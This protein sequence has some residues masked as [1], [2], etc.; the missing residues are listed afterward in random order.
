MVKKKMNRLLRPNMSVFFFAMGA[1]SIAAFILEQYWLG[2]IQG[3]A[4]LLLYAINNMDRRHRHRELS[5]YLLEVENTLE[6]SGQGRSPF[7]AVMVRLGDGG[8]AWTNQ[9]FSRL[10]ISRGPKRIHRLSDDFPGSVLI[11]RVIPKGF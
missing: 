2:T 5:K 6:F 4:A 11:G 8:I 9:R 1:F 7:P 10:H 3:A